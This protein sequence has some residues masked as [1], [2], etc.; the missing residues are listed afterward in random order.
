MRLVETLETLCLQVIWPQSPS[1]AVLKSDARMLSSQQVT[2]CLLKQVI[3]R[4]GPARKALEGDAYMTET[5][6]EEVPHQELM[7]LHQYSAERAGDA[8]AVVWPA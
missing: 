1:V 5:G 4:H 2:T 7:A 8:P 6:Q 3:G